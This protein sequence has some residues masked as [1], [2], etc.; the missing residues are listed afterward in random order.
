M[1]GYIPHQIETNSRSPRHNRWQAHQSVG[2][3][4][5]RR[6]LKPDHRSLQPKISHFVPPSSATTTEARAQIIESVENRG[7]NKQIKPNPLLHRQWP[8]IAAPTTTTAHRAIDL[9]PPIWSKI[10]RHHH[11]PLRRNRPSP[12]HCFHFQA[13]NQ[14]PLSAIEARAPPSSAWPY[15][16]PNRTQLMISTAELSTSPLNHLLVSHP[17]CHRPRKPDYRS[18]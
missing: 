3:F 5:Q 9:T 10:Y 16:P 17:L 15:P 4:R 2:S 11:I 7:N 13:I 6:P 14:A 1:L 8:L 12:H 18:L